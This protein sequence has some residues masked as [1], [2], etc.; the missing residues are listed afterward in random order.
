MEKNMGDGYLWHGL[1]TKGAFKRCKMAEEYEDYNLACELIHI[2]DYPFPAGLL[3]NDNRETTIQ[4]EFNNTLGRL[5]SHL[6]DFIQFCPNT[7]SDGIDKKLRE[8]NEKVN[9]LTNKLAKITDPEMCQ[10]IGI[11]DLECE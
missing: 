8:I 7:F 6:H 11:S 4:F 2:R 3:P 1:K 10:F 9:N 5:A